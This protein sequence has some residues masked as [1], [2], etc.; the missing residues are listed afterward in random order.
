LAVTIGTDGRPTHITVLRGHPLLIQSS[1]DAVKQWVY[2]P[3]SQASSFE[4][5]VNFSLPPGFSAEPLPEGT[6]RKGS[7]GASAASPAMASGTYAVPQ[8]IKVGGK[9]QQAMLATKVDPV[10]PALAKTAGIQG[11]VTLA[12]VIGKDGSVQNISAIDGH[13]LLVAAAI[14]AVKQ[15]TYKGTTLDGKPVE[16]STTVTVPFELQP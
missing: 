14:D 3:V 12:I 2:A 6:P 16:V 5:E 13:P 15:W 7:Q 10:Y 9:V 4:Q 11:N 1:L 8:R